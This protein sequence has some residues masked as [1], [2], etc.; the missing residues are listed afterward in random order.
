[1]HLMQEFWTKHAFSP[2]EHYLCIQLASPFSSCC[3]SVLDL[4][5]KHLE[6]NELSSFMQNGGITI[7]QLQCHSNL[8]VTSSSE[9]VTSTPAPTWQCIM[10]KPHSANNDNNAT[11]CV[12]SYPLPL[13]SNETF[14]EQFSSNYS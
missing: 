14:F 5:A 9:M 11:Q 2:N 6:D 8:T 1:M 10:L 13:A 3:S 4:E 7:S 12:H